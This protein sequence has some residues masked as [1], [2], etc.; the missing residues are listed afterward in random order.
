MSLTDLLGEMQRDPWP[1]HQAKRPLRATGAALSVAVGL[2]EVFDHPPTSSSLN[3]ILVRVDPV[4]QYGCSSDVIHRWSVHARA[5]YDRRRR[6]EKH[7]SI[8]S[9]HRERQRQIHEKSDQSRRSRSALNFARLT[10][11]SSVLRSVRHPCSHQ[12]SRDRSVLIGLGS[13]RSTRNE[14]LLELHRVSPDSME[15]DEHD[16][17]RTEVTW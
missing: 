7:H 4:S 14:V 17:P 9:R 16:C 10:R 12:R 11:M 5:G 13:N 8:A 6:T 2:L 3:I 1:V 15:I